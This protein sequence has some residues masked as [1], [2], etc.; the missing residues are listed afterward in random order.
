MPN[1]D[2]R[3]PRL[4]GLIAT[5]FVLG[6][7]A[8]LVNVAWKSNVAI[9]AVEAAPEPSVAAGDSDAFLGCTSCHLDLDKVFKQGGADGLLY[10]HKR[11]FAKG[12]SDCSM[13]HP[14]NVHVNDTINKPTMTRCFVCHGLTK[15]AIAPGTCTTCHPRDFSKLPQSHKKASW[16]TAHG[17]KSSQEKIPCGVCHE[18]KTCSSCH[19]VTMPH[20]KGWKKAPHVKAFFST[21][22]EVCAR[23]HPRSPSSGGRD[24][25]DKCHHREGPAGTSWLRYHRTVVKSDFGKKCFSCHSSETCATCHQTG[26]TDF[27]PDRKAALRR[28]SRGK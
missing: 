26:T 22:M 15:L 11:H 8:L 6:V 5:V 9:R 10:R 27:E 14:V 21:G 1:P 7:T 17:K 24:F 2:R 25:C 28:A 18:D 19:G 4:A 20:A 13:C 12:V 16:A 3:V 23:C